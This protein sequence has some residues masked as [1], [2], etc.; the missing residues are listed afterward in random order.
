MQEP[1]ALSEVLS[2]AQQTILQVK[3]PSKRVPSHITASLTQICVSELYKAHQTVT[4]PLRPHLSHPSH[5]V[6]PTKLHNM[7]P[8]TQPKPLQKEQHRSLALLPKQPIARRPT[9]T[10]PVVSSRTQYRGALFRSN[11]AH[12]LESKLKHACFTN[13]IPRLQ[14][15]TSCRSPPRRIAITCA[16]NR[17]SKRCWSAMRDAVDN[18]RGGQLPRSPSKTSSTAFSAS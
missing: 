12:A 16:G 5:L 3:V 9:R 11:G 7:L 6:R 2:E 18:S 10:L 8:T 14:L 13:Q 17:G 4:L 15:S 1:K